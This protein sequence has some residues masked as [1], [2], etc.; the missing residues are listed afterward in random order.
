VVVENNV[1][2]RGSSY[3]VLVCAV[4]LSEKYKPL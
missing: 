4:L 3:S 1:H 2:A